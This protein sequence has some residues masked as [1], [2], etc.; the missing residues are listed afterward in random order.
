[1]NNKYIPTAEEIK[2]ADE[3]LKL[4][5]ALTGDKSFETTYNEVSKEKRGGITMDE[6]VQ[7][8][9]NEGRDEGKAEIIRKM[10][11]AKLVSEQQIASLLKISVDEVKKIAAKI[12]VHA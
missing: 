6:I 12:P 2:H 9:K 7:G 1:M 10:L 3:L 8:F 11:D 5:T 4:F